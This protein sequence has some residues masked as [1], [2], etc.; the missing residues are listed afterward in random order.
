MQN[1][2]IQVINLAIVERWEGEGEGEDDLSPSI[3]TLLVPNIQILPDE[4][5]TLALYQTQP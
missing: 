2:N 5:L 3:Q 1:K 4:I